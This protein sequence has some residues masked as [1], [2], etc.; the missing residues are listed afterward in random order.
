[1]AAGSKKNEGG[2][3]VAGPITEWRGRGEP[4]VLAW[5]AGVLFLVEGFYLLVYTA[6]LPFGSLSLPSAGAISVIA[7]LTLIFLGAFYRSYGDARPY[8]GTLIVLIAAGDLWF[9]GGFWVGSVFG[10][11][12]GVLII[13]LPPY[14]R[15][16]RPG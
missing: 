10:T 5:V 15:T 6:S 12:A 7:G 11:I 1:M 4:I 2:W 13:A 14:P 8:F 16:H 3:N 9:G